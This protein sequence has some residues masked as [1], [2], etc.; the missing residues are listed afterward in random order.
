MIADRSWLQEVARVIMASKGA[1]T[2]GIDGI[3]KQNNRAGYPVPTLDMIHAELLSGGYQP[4]PARRSL[5]SEANG[6]Q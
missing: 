5:Y 4:Q 3:D 6:K 2:P 1:R